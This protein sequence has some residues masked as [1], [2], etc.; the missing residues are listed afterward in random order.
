ML[1]SP[2]PGK[3]P[4]LTLPA[5]GSH[6]EH[7]KE[8]AEKALAPSLTQGAQKGVGEVGGFSLTLSL[9][10]SEAHFK[11]IPGEPGVGCR[12]APSGPRVRWDGAFGGLLGTPGT[13]G[14]N[15]Q[16]YMHFANFPDS[17]L[18]SAGSW[19]I[20]WHQEG[21]IRLG[22]GGDKTAPN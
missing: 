5:P 19:A 16:R 9:S 10:S 12:G 6:Q 3:H 18:C 20:L 11:S 22:D 4:G 2:S 8:V 7:S 14:I 13:P 1:A 17:P 15:P 21:M